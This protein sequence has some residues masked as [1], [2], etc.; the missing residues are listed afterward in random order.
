M[1]KA[2]KRTWQDDPLATVM[3]GLGL[4]GIVWILGMVL[5]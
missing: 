4:A 5:G 1:I 2:L 3:T